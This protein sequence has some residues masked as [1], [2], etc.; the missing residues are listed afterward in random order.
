MNTVLWVSCWL[1]RYA[2]TG[3]L[4]LLLTDTAQGPGYSLAY[5]HAIDIQGKHGVTNSLWMHICMLYYRYHLI[6]WHACMVAC[7][8]ACIFFPY[9]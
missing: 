4:D 5:V 1:L 7:T 3:D 8:V 6:D 9:S 2:D